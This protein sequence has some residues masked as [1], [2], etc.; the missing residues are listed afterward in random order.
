MIKKSILIKEVKREFNSKS[1][2][3]YS[4]LKKLLKDNDLIFNFFLKL[5]FQTQLFNLRQSNQRKRC[6]ITG[7]SRGYLSFFGFG[8]HSLKDLVRENILPGI[9]KSSW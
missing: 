4:I 5:H 2:L 3:H 7:R 8:R 6:R 1:S 9:R